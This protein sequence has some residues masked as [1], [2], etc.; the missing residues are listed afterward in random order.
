MKVFEGNTIAEVYSES[1]EDIEK[2]I[3]IIEALKQS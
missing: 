3:R 1:K 2:A